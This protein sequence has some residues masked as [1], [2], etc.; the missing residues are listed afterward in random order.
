[1]AQTGFDSL[2]YVQRLES[3]GVERPTA[4]AH[5]EL[6]RD[7]VL[8]EVAT[9]ADLARVEER[10]SARIERGEHQLVIRMGAMLAAAVGLI[11][12][13]QKLL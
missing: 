12:A 6:I 1:M 8:S 9:R 10:L 4:E 7:M 2:A 3:V 13:A 5:A 11:V